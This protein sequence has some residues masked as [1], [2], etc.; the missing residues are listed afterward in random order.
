MRSSSVSMP[1]SIQ[2]LL[3]SLGRDAHDV[4]HV[5]GGERD[6]GVLAFWLSTVSWTGGRSV[7]L[8]HRTCGPSPC[9]CCPDDRIGIRRPDPSGRTTG[10]CR[11]MGDASV[12]GR[13]S[14]T[15]PVPFRETSVAMK[16]VA[17]CASLPLFRYTW[18]LETPM[19]SMRK[20]ALVERPIVISSWSGTCTRVLCSAMWKAVFMLVTSLISAIGRV[21]GEKIPPP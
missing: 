11:G 16:M 20:S 19:L 13:P 18:K 10:I 6:A 17:P 3:T 9:L 8:S 5:L 12:A 14:L 15:M 4:G 7:A 2:M 1:S 21:V